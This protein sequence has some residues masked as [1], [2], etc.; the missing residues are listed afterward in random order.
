MF[1]K[2]INRYNRVLLSSAALLILALGLNEFVFTKDNSAQSTRDAT[3]DAAIA[4]SILAE[5]YCPCGCGNFLPGSANLPACFGCSVGKAEITRVLEGLAA[6]RIPED[7]IDELNEKVLVDVFSDYTESKL[8]EVW[9]LVK[10]VSNAFDQRRVVLRPLGATEDARRAI[11]LVECARA[12]GKF[13]T[14]HEALIEHTGLW[15]R[16]TLLALATKQGLAGNKITECFDSVDIAAQMA[17]DRQHAQL[18]NTNNFPAVSVNRKLCLPNEEALRKA[19][20]KVLI[21]G[22]I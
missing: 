9:D 2:K 4:Q 22:T 14:M 17:K 12:E 13:N 5:R 10:R 6:G 7:I 19:I 16:A 11:K 1:Y 20:R 18:L 3:S 15:D 21:E 8:L